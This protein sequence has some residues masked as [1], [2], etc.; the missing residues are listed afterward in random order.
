MSKSRS[1]SRL[2]RSGVALLLAAALA[3]CSSVGS[4][5][6]S[7]DRSQDVGTTADN[8]KDGGTLTMALSAE[9]DF[10]DPTLAG[11]FYSR[12][13]FNAMCEKLYD[14]N[15][16]VRIVPQLAASL[17]TTS[18]DGRT[19]TIKLR[20]G[21]KFADGTT[22]NSS[23][24]KISLERDLN[25]PQSARVTELGPI[26][27]ID[28]PDASTVVIHLKTPFAPLTAALADRAGMVMSPTQL[29]KLGDKFG[30]DPVCVGPFKFASRVPQNSITLVKDPNYYDADKVHLDK[31]VYRIITDSAIRAANLKSGDVQVADT[32]GTN[33]VSSIKSDSSLQMLESE[34]LGY[35]GLTFNVGNTAGVGKPPGKIQAPYAQDPR[36]RQAFEY[37]ID[38]KALVKTVFD[39]QFDP[40]CGPIAPESQFST[41][42]VQKC[43]PY[44]PDKAKQLLQQAG[45]PVPYQLNMLVTN[46]PDSLQFAQALQAMVKPAGFD[47]KLQPLEFT[48]LL[49]QQD[50]GKFQLLQ[51][52]WSGR[53][54]PDANITNFVGTQGS[55]NVAGYS[56]P[57]VD[58]LL[59]QARETQDVA[60]RA[61]LYG[62]VQTQTEVD[63]PIIYIYRQRNLTGVSKDV[64]GV[65]VYPDGIIR[66]A[67]AGY[68]K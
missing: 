30:T 20:Q 32:V 31:I 45:V 2:T 49:D 7:G 62:Q 23:A 5:S 13:V 64:S 27:S 8:V 52:G 22:M 10:L 33:D 26:T 66:V 38:R 36:I 16:S 1:R 28:T 21:V 48:T 50:Q 53:V 55:Q 41:P 37:A 3:A 60:Q 11:S 43:R 34:S 35:Q 51:L 14:L 24:V 47:L 57:K 54:D 44:D 15:A 4:S 59:A 19:V 12:Y 25:N 17:P 40:A 67:F 18:K 42:A 65:Q 56:S 29:K 6:P 9:P 68:A 61:R 39:G 63:D 58:Q 46:T